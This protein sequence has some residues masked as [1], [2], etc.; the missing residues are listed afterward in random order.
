[1]LYISNFKGPLQAFSLNA[2]TAKLTAM[3]N[4]SP[5]TFAKYGPTASVSSA[6]DNSNGIVWAIDPTAYCTQQAPTCGPAVLRAYDPTNLSNELWHSA[7][8]SGDP[9]A[10][11]NAVK[12]TVPTIANGKVYVGT[13]GN[14]AGGADN[15]TTIPGEL[16]VFGL[17]HN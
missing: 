6:P 15:S 11:G 16:D 10:A 7:T 1:M 14:N 4:V 13:R 9:N 5:E 8:V 2:S 3:S 17:L 12:F